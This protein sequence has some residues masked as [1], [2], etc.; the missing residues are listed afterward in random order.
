MAAATPLNR[1]PEPPALPSDVLDSADVQTFLSDAVQEFVE[2]IGGA[3]RGFVW[4]I[5]H[6]GPG[7][8]RN[9]AAGSAKAR[10]VDSVQNSFADGPSL[11]AAASRE[12]V[13]IPDAAVDRRWPGF[14][15]AVVGQGV[16]SVLSVPIFVERELSGALTL[17]AA[18]PHAFT[19]EDVVRAAACARRLSKVCRLLLE[20]ARNA[21]P[22]ITQPPLSVTELALWSLIREYGLTKESAMRYLQAVVRDGTVTS[23]YPRTG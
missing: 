10:E 23:P 5:T 14:S 16:R 21:G 18:A 15:A 11:T 9:W 8:L 12:F 20:L 17:Y 3:A 7:D 22:A 1:Q 4:A 2:D 6:A 19:S 13:H